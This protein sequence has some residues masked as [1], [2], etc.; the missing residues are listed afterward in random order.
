MCHYTG[1]KSVAC[2]YDTGGK[3]ISSVNNAS[4]KVITTV[5]S[6]RPLVTVSNEQE[7]DQ[8]DYT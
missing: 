2:A 1:G 5:L 4:G 3:L 8:L 7:Q 6:T